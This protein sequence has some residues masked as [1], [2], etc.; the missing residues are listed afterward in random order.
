MDHRFG[1]LLQSCGELEAVRW[2]H[3]STYVRRARPVAGQRNLAKLFISTNRHVLCRCG[4]LGDACTP[5][6]LDD[7]LGES[8]QIAKKKLKVFMRIEESNHD[9]MR[10]TWIII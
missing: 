3:S 7:S 2:L 4:G 9:N 10:V 1:W 6:W 5:T 8:R